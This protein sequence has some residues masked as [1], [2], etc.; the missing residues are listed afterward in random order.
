LD[1][2]NRDHAEHGVSVAEAEEAYLGEMLFLGT[3][4]VSGFCL[5]R[6]RI[7]LDVE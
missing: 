4:C 5:V 7:W 1:H 6:E 3:G 2:A